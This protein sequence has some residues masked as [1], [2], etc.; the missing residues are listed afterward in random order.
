MACACLG[1]LVRNVYSS[2]CGA[3]LEKQ[4]RGTCEGDDMCMGLI[5]L[6]QSL[7]VKNS[8]SSEKV[9]MH[10]N[11]QPNCLLQCHSGD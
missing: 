1:F 8:V 6:I 5:E 2:M 3:K 10:L 9:L 4:A 7:K 11:E